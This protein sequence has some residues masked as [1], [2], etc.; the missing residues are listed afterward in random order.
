MNVACLAISITHPKLDGLGVG[1]HSFLTHR[2]KAIFNN[3]PPQP[4]YSLTWNVSFVT[5][6]LFPFWNNRFL[7]LKQLLWNL[8]M[9]FTLICSASHC[10]S[11]TWN[12]K[13]RSQLPLEGG[14][15]CFWRPLASTP[16]FSK[17]T[18]RGASTTAAANSNVPLSD[19]LKM[20]DWFTPTF[21]TFYYKP[22]HICACSSSPSL[23]CQFVKLPVSVGNSD[24][25]FAVIDIL[26]SR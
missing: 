24:K 11:P 14:S 15:I 1:Q 9:L 2:L 3:R 18:L 25:Q 21:Q 10:S 6:D 5:K 4:S 20:T 13:N 26:N 17:H 12:R 22:I 19:I 16:I 7:P 23:Y 8:A